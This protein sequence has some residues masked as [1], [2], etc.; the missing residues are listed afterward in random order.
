[1]RQLHVEAAYGDAHVSNG[2]GGRV[3]STKMVALVTGDSRP[4]ETVISSLR[5]T[6]GTWQNRVTWLPLR[7]AYLVVGRYDDDSNYGDTPRELD[8]RLRRVAGDSSVSLR[9][10]SYGRLVMEEGTLTSVES[11]A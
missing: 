4:D 5:Q 9:I 6:G 1:M 2:L 8:Q 7:Q 11:A 3:K 10:H